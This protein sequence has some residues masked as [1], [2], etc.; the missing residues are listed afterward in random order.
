MN[1]ETDLDRHIVI[2][3]A[4][5]TFTPSGTRITTGPITAVDKLAALINWVHPRDLL[6]TIP[7]GGADDAPARLWVIGEGCQLL[8][9]AEAEEDASAG[10]GR[11]L[12]TLVGQGWELSR[13]PA[14]RY[15][16]ARTIDGR[17]AAVEIVLDTQSWLTGSTRS[18]DAAEFGRRLIRWAAVV[19]V[20]PEDSGAASGAAV[21]DQ[22]MADRVSRSS[23]VVVTDPGVLPGYVDLQPHIQPPWIA[24]SA[25][26]ERQFD[27]A[28]DLVLLEQECPQLA[29]AGMLDFGFGAPRSLT[30]DAAARA[31]AVTKRPFALW[32]GQIPATDSLGC[33]ATLPPPHPAAHPDRSSG[34]VWLTT[35][36][37]HG[38]CQ[39]VREGGAGLT[40]DQLK[41]DAAIV[42]PQETRIL[43]GWAKRLRAARDAFADDPAMRERVEA[44][45]AEYLSALSD[46]PTWAE[47]ARRRHYQPAWLAAIAASVRFRSRRAAMRLSIS[48]TPTWPVYAADAAMIYALGYDK[49]GRPID[50]ADNHKTNLGRMLST[51]RSA[52]TTDALL[53]ILA[54]ETDEDIARALTGQ[55]GVAA[56]P[57]TATPVGDLETPT[58][59]VDDQPDPELDR[60]PAEIGADTDPVDPE[61]A[62]ADAPASGEV[63]RDEYEPAEPP[64]PVQ[65][66]AGRSRSKTSKGRTP[67]PAIDNSRKIPAGVLDTDGL[68][69]P[70]GTRIELAEPIRHVGQLADLAYEHNIGYP[71]SPTYNEQAQIWIT[72][73]ACAAFGIDIESLTEVKPRDRGKYLRANTTDIPFVTEAVAAG[74][75]LGGSE[76]GDDSEAPRLRVWTRVFRDV[77]DKEKKRGVFIVLIPGI[78]AAS[79][80]E[81]T[82]KLQMPIL[83]GSPTAVQI[84][85]RLK[86]LAD[87]L[88]YP[89]KINAGVTSIDIMLQARPRT[90]KFEEWRDHVHGPSTTEPPFGITDVENVFDWS[91]PPTA[92]ELV[93]R[94]VHAYDRGASYVA[95]IAGLELPIGEPVHYTDGDQFD[96]NKPGY[97]LIN[98]PEPTEWLMPFLLNPRGHQFTGPKWVCTPILEQARRMGYDPDILEAL[99]WHEHGRVFEKWYELFRTASTVLDI[100]DAD[101]QAARDQAKVVRTRGIG[102]IG[103]EQHYKEKT[104]YSPERRLHIMSQANANIAYR[105]I[106]I[107]Q[108]TG[109]WPVAVSQDTVLYVSDDPNPETAWP[110]GARTFGRGFGKYKPEASALLADHL[111]HLNGG[112]YRG[113]RHLTPADEWKVMD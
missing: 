69:L 13:T 15:V 19:G 8:L 44:A 56:A 31:A 88:G 62:D 106:E 4:D 101:S 64:T 104:G 82:V 89:W 27:H 84:A 105:I 57:V 109:R 98:V 26:M 80:P 97:W 39:P 85:R 9:G 92:D 34:A 58:E 67:K 17:R 10:L 94:Y 78:F 93:Q 77:D 12:A 86:L 40:V 46:A 76:K 21:L 3:S 32:R 113:K 11:A 51:A 23:G 36:D 66:K 43:D 35:Q 30:G 112:V 95:A 50:L 75:S 102:I 20:L 96:G 71:L 91:R 1:V 79:D 25:L 63:K 100:D 59:R 6:N 87:V 72:E 53:A 103:S 24:P 60:T 41:I 108:A 107:G 47:P 83:W 7:T 18:E 33:P 54:A 2:A 45:A 110:G 38:L 52:L 61:P 16:V 28:E 14:G 74:W 70:D 29:S 42:W 73:Q 49:N 111:E 5:G 90:W 68:W 99:V 37:L 81:G 22:I 48:P 55:L 65:S